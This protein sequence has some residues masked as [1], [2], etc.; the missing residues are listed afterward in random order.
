MFCSNCGSA[1]EDGAKFCQKC[2]QALTA[3]APAAAPSSPPPDTRMRDTQVASSG[4]HTVTGKNPVLAAVISII[5]GV[6]QFYNGDNKKGGVILG[7]TI[8]L[9]LLTAGLGGLVWLAMF[10]WA[11][12][13]A[14][15]VADGKGKTW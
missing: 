8:V 14:Y 3:D 4:G 11:A 9:N 7:L 6:G 5:P 13:D 10:L 1:N 15:R 12:I 2:G